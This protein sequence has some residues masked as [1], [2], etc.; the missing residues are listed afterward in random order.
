L[1]K[2]IQLTWQPVSGAVTYV[3]KVPSTTNPNS[4]S[5]VWSGTATSYTYACATGTSAVFVLDAA[6]ING[7]SA[8]S[9]ATQPV[10]AK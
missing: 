8:D 7:A 5:I 4:Y 10:T 2:A 6:N 9:A 1:T 3:V